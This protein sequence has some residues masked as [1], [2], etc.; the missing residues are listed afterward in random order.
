MSQEVTALDD[1]DIEEIYNQI[2]NGE[3]DGAE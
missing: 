2:I 1:A 3:G